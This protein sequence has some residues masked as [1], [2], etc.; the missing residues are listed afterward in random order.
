VIGKSQFY[1]SAA[2]MDNGIESVK[3][4]GATTTIEDLTA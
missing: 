3:K 2:A 1:A 4:N